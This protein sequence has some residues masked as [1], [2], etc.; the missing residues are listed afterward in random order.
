MSV[1]WVLNTLITL[2]PR[3]YGIDLVGCFGWQMLGNLVWFLCVFFYWG[4]YLFCH[5]LWFPR[6]VLMFI[7]TITWFIS[8][9]RICSSLV[10]PKNIETKSSTNLFNI[11]RA[12]TPSLFYLQQYSSLIWLLSLPVL[13]NFQHHKGCHYR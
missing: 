4:L 8:F 10:V 13:W 11:G 5:L 12:S 2:S 9:K 6:G 3:E 7:L 1:C